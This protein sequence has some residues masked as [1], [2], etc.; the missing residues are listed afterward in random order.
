MVKGHI[1]RCKVANSMLLLD[2]GSLASHVD[3]LASAFAPEVIGG[4]ISNSADAWGEDSLRV[5]SVSD[6]RSSKKKNIL[7]VSRVI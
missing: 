4:V 5:C 2:L 6:L 3:K 7:P 1:N